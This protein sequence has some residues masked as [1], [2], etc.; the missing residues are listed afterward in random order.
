MSPFKSI[1]CTL[2]AKYGLC[3]LPK[4]PDFMNLKVLT[5]VIMKK[6]YLVQYN[7]VEST[8]RNLM[9]GGLRDVIPQKIEVFI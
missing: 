2:W 3:L 8:E 9:L 1:L 4:H 5:A 7:A 6:L